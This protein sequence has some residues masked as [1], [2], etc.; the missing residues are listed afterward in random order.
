M[1]TPYPLTGYFKAMSVRVGDYPGF[2]VPGSYRPLLAVLT[3]RTP[4][5]EGACLR[6]FKIFALWFCC[7]LIDS[8]RRVR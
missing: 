3:D 2:A 7:C 1:S 5:A 4:S 6:S 8:L